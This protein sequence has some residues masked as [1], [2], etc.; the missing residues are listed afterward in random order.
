MKN[1]ANLINEVRH[2]WEQ[3]SP[4]LDE[5]GRRIWAGVESKQIGAGGKT[6]VHE[7]T[8]M[9]RR[10][11]AKGEQET[12]H[13]GSVPKRI[14]RAGGGRRPITE[15]IP[16]LSERIET[17]VEPHTKGDPV[18]P[19]RWTS[20]STYK[21]SAELKSEGLSVSPNTVGRILEG[22]DYSLQLNRKEKEG[23]EHVDRNEQFELIN[24][25]VE[26]FTSQGRAAISVDTKKK[27]NIGNYKN[28][29]REY[30]RAG[31]APEVKVYDFVD[32]ELGKVAPY[33]VY[34]LRLNKGWV[35]VGI[36]SDTAAFAVNS[37]RS[38]YCQMGQSEY[39]ETD[40]LLITADCGGSN[41][42]RSKLWKVELQKFAN[43]IQKAIHVCHFPPGTSK[44]NKIEHKMFCF[45]TMNWR[46]KPL[47]TRQTVVQL[48][49]STTTNSGLKIRAV[50]D[51]NIY[52]KGVIVPDEELTNVNLVEEKFHGEW[53]YRIEPNKI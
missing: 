1:R 48:I 7:A 42:N 9:S 49:G 22:M 14:R 45:I 21:L 29:G 8:G 37:I 31:E 26:E 25:K 30:H 33:G 12:A 17:L 44:W 51:E 13:R 35:S 43:E 47:T 27:E 11:I 19:L 3:I 15:K 5:R 34:D 36:S 53:N 10:T 50:V 16:N 18:R 40:A 2:K 6:I 41:S 39:K 23:G 38:W 32:K 28:G 24:R 20:K 46:G 52:Q 4:F